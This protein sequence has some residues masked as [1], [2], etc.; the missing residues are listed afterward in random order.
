M[1]LSFW[2]YSADLQ[3]AKLVVYDYYQEDYSFE[4]IQNEWLTCC[5]YV[6]TCNKKYF[7]NKA[8]RVFFYV[9]MSGNGNENF[10]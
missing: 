8:E 9:H 5:F 2:Y 10:D 7:I 3:D 6:H 4:Y 1:Q